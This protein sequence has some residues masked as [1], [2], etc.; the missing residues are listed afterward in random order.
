M[1]RENTCFCYEENIP[2]PRREQVRA[3]IQAIVPSFD[4]GDGTF[5]YGHHGAYAEEADD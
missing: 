4:D 3:R 5:A 2:N 1:L